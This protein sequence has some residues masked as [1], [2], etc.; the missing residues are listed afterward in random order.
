LA[1]ETVGSVFK[2]AYYCVLVRILI[3]NSQNSRIFTSFKKNFCSTLLLHLN[4][5][6]ANFAAL[7]V[8]VVLADNHCI[9]FVWNGFEIDPH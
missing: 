2:T 6:T 4:Q 1:E 3:F 9:Y 8:A 7:K 5:S